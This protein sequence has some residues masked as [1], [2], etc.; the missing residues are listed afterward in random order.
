[1]IMTIGFLHDQEMS[2]LM[3]TTWS[4]Y[5]VNLDLDRFCPSRLIISINT[6]GA[7]STPVPPS[8]HPTRPAPNRPAVAATSPPL[9]ILFHLPEVSFVTIAESAEVQSA[10][11]DGLGDHAQGRAG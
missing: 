7:S 11:R 1:M 9:I 4:F 5:Y 3:S 2:F 8:P 6:L 10:Q